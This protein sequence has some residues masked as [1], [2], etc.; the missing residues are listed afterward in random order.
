MVSPGLYSRVVMELEGEGEGAS[1]P[2]GRHFDIRLAGKV[3]G[4]PAFSLT[5][6]GDDFRIDVSAATPFD[7]L[8]GGRLHARVAFDLGQWLQGITLPP[9][10]PVVVDATQHPELLPRFRANVVRSAALTFE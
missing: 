2:A 9:G 4:G 3:V 5:G 10:D 6:A 1:A 8:P 7:L